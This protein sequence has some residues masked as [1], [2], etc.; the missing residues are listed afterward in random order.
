MA[1]HGLIK[2]FEKIRSYMRDFYVY[3]F[4][5]RDAFDSKSKRVYDDESR[6]VKGWLQGYID[7]Y[8]DDSGKKVFLSIDS[9]S[10]S[11]NPL[12][13]AFRTK[14][15]TDWDIAL[16][17]FLLDILTDG[18]ATVRQC[19]DRITETLPEAFAKELPDEGTIRNKLKEYERMGIVISRKEGRML[20]YALANDFSEKLSWR[21]AAD[22]FSESA[23]MG[24]IG[25]YFPADHTSPFEFK[26]QYFL[27]ALDSE[28]MA[29]LCEC[30]NQHR[31]SEL[32]IFSRRKNRERTH[33]V[34]PLRFYFSTQSGRQYILGYH[35]IFKKPMF[36]RLDSI[37]KVK[38]LGIEK[39]PERYEAYWK[40]FDQNLWGVSP[41][42]QTMDHVRMWVRVGTDEFHIPERL[43]REKRHGSIRQIN[44][45]TWEFEADVYRHEDETELVIKL[46]SFGPVLKVVEP[47]RF[48]TLIRERIER[49][50]RL[51]Y[52]MDSPA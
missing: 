6:R 1:Y 41:G 22:F 10:I 28:I 34:Y 9:R 47:E 50:Y 40:A 35:Y 33:T 43:N 39:N 20:I 5:G 23:P 30:M 3:G 21:D 13:V 38:Q 12:Y 31:G 26:H 44:D 24:V 17:F 51:Q 48:V 32:T 15:F 29:E 49:Q 4:K 7:S 11:R 42:E 14:S 16:H 18:P 46:L 37:R 25:S 45:E 52:L 19:L 27:S 8:Y 36:F 2:N